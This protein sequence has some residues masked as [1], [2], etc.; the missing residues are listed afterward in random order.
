M[1]TRLLGS[2]PTVAGIQKVINTFYASDHYRVDPE[3]LAVTN[4]TR[5]V[6]DG[7]RVVKFGRGYRFERIVK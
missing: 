1:Q 7:I 4:A 3:T 6:P 5:G 2:S